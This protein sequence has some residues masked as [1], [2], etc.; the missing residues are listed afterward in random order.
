MNWRAV[1]HQTTIDTHTRLRMLAAAPRINPRK[2]GCAAE[3]DG[4]RHKIQQASAVIR[5]ESWRYDVAAVPAGAESRWETLRQLGDQWTGIRRF[6]GRHA[7][8]RRCPGT[9]G[10]RLQPPAW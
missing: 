8:R 7:L 4:M 10:D 2:E 1:R 3:S 6:S 5:E 9:N